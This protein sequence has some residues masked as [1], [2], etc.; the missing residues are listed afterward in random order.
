[1]SARVPAS[2]RLTVPLIVLGFAAVLSAVNFLYHV[3][4]AEQAAEQD[5]LKRVAQEM[6][7][8]QS[9]LEY[10]LLRGDIEIAQREIAVL[11]HNHDYVFVVLTDDRHNVIAATRRA[12]L[13]RS[14]Y[15]V[16]PRFDFVQASGAIRERRAKL[17]IDP[18]DNAV[19]GYA[20]IFMA[21]TPEEL[22]PSRA[23][24]LFLE[25]DLAGP[26]SEARAQVLQ[27]SLYWAG[28]V[29][30]LAL[31]MWLLFHFLLTRRTARLVHAAEQLA[32]GDLSARSALQGRDELARLSRA[33][34]AMA[35][36]VADTQNR[37]RHDLA[38]RIR[39]QRE[40]GESEASYRAIFDA[41]EDAIF[42]HDI[43]SGAIIDVN[44]KAC[45]GYGYTREELLRADAGV[46]RTGEPPYTREDAQALAASIGSGARHFERRGTNRDASPRWDEVFIKRVPIQGQ[47]RMLVLTRDITSRKLAEAALRA[48]EEQYR[49]MFNASIDGLALWN[50][51]GALVEVNP[52]LYRMYGFADAAD[53]TSA[54]GA[55]VPLTYYPEFLRALE[56]GEPWLAERT[57]LR[58]DGSAFELEVHAIPMQYQGEPHLLSIARDVTDKKHAAEE[59]S[60]Q[61]EALH[62]REKLAALGSLLAGVAHELNNPLSVVVARA[63]MLEEMAAGSTQVAAQK[64]RA[65]ADRCARIVRTFLAMARQEEPRRG[66]VAINEVVAAALEITAYAVRTSS[67][68]LALDLESAMP[69]IHADADQLHQV[70]LNLVINAQQ[71][72]QDQPMPRRLSIATRLDQRSATIRIKVADN[73]PGIPPEVRKRVFEP[74]FTTKPIGI[75]TGVGLA[76][77]HGIIEAHGGSIEV[78][79]PRE[80]GTSFHITLP[81]GAPVPASRPESAVQ[82]TALG[83]RNILVVDDEVEVRELLAEILRTAD[84]RVTQ[85][86][87]GSEALA[88]LEVEHFELVVT[89]IR[90][91]DLDGL[92]LYREIRRRWPERNTHVVFV[93][94]DTL[95]PSSRELLQLGDCRVIEKPFIPQEVRR[96]V[97]DIVTRPALSAPH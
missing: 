41:A 84:T 27:Q 39:I 37:L 10:L 29:A 53:P 58:S 18:V 67:I 20:G 54:P 45:A 70:M 85:A 92:G 91:P 78:E 31:V 94:G 90:M 68:E 60:R 1:M 33:F 24:T 56:R 26:K 13:Q 6:S 48:S 76:V 87:S 89:D 15:D 69:L 36:E 44:P 59:L 35:D 77:S 51:A 79:C 75:G 63:V 21:S 71:A 17:A 34:D 22:R 38:E 8:L 19:H 57:A 55:L 43:G 3:P 93:T 50:A 72:L 14:I 61:R 88:R 25:H 28:W 62:Q 42:V 4:R 97:A 16:F 40:L 86:G 12:W 74:Y 96:I 65:A 32:A 47:D 73:G 66:A 49:A 23:G 7:R 64:I 11:A 46:L 5:A 2:L 9:T 30:G 82:P 80:G 95:S 81:V 52:A 83:R